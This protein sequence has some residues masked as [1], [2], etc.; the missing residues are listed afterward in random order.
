MPSVLFVCTA[1]RFRSPL[2]AALFRHRLKQEP[3]GHDWSAASAGTWA[4]PDKVVIPPTKWAANHLHLDLNAHKSRRINRELLNAYDLVLVMENN[5]REGLLVEFPEMEDRTFLLSMVAVGQTY[6]I[7]DP[8]VQPGDTFQ[9]VADEL[10]GLID[11]GYRNICDLA[12][13]LHDSKGQ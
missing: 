3:D 9:D 1:D 7:P 8:H 11:K 2:A 4:D 5:H 13:R 10:C 6:N 12:R